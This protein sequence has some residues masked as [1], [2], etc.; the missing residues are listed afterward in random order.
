MYNKTVLLNITKNLQQ[1]IHKDMSISR[2]KF[3]LSGVVIIYK[4]RSSKLY[5]I[6]MNLIGIEGLRDKGN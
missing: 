5:Y 6:T 3:Q 4:K 1:S 2:L